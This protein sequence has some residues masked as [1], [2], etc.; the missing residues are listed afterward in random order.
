[1]STVSISLSEWA[2]RFGQAARQLRLYAHLLPTRP[3]W[4]AM[5]G[6]FEQQ[7][8]GGYKYPALLLLPLPLPLPEE[9]EDDED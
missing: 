1:M 2:L 4:D 9:E 7:A 6:N 5:L 3:E 8:A